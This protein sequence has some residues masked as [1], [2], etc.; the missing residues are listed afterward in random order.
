VRVFYFIE[1]FTLNYNIKSNSQLVCNNHTDQEIEHSK[2]L[3]MGRELQRIAHDSFCDVF[4]SWPGKA[5]RAAQ[6]LVRTL[7]SAAAG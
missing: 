7:G 1:R 6:R 2:Q 4:M 5:A 3:M